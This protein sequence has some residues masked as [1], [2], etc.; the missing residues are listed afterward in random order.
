MKTVQKLRLLT[1]NTHKGFSILNRRFVLH[2]LREAIREI[3]A[4][5]VFLQEVIGEHHLHRQRYEHWPEKSQYEFLADA[6][7]KDFAYGRNAI[8]S[9]GD[10]G[11]ALLSKFTITHS[12]QHDLSLYHL[13]QRG[14]LH[15]EIAIPGFPQSFHCICIHLN[16][17]AF[18]RRQQ[19]KMIEQYIKEQISPDAPLLI[20]GDF[21]DW[22]KQA[23]HLFASRLNLFECHRLLHGKL[24]KT[25]PSF[26]PVLCLDRIYGRGFEVKE[27]M[28]VH[29]PP[30]S[31]LSDHLPLIAEMELHVTL[32]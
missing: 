6:L 31:T 9:S 7:W 12:H 28:T 23:E 3:S 27:C 24:A 5:L 29:R 22:G 14:L 18:H 32:D 13:E 10:H 16:L 20:A 2:E 17:L 11:N 26:H 19:Y 15:C 4:D 1:I 8:Y 25:F 30:W 21:N